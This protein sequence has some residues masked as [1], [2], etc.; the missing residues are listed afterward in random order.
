ML[1]DLQ[2]PVQRPRD[3]FQLVRLH[4]FQMLGNDLLGQRVLRI[5]SLQLQQET[6]AQI[7]RAHADRI[8]VLH[9]GE[10][11]IEVILR[12]FSILRQLLGGSRQITVLVQVADDALDD[13]FHHVRTDRDAQ[14]PLEMVS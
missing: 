13:L 11:V 3:L 8:E 14:L 2:G 5:E 7:S 6:F 1:D 4:L 10:R 12:I 9:H